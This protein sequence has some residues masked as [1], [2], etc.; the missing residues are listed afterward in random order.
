M[1]TLIPSYVR[2]EIKNKTGMVIDSYGNKIVKNNKDG[3]NEI[4][5]PDESYFIIKII[6][7]QQSNQKTR[8]SKI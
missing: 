7:I 4:K 1:E 5:N 2:N 8:I 6:A 3:K